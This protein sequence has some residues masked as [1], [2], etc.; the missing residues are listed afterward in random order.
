MKQ[1]SQP[2]T[3][4]NL[5]KILNQKLKYKAE[6]QRVYQIQMGAFCYSKP[7]FPQYDSRYPYTE[8]NNIIKS[9]SIEEDALHPDVSPTVFKA[10]RQNPN[11]SD[12]KESDF[13][14][15]WR[16]YCPGCRSLHSVPGRLLCCHVNI[17]ARFSK[18]E[19]PEDTDKETS[20][21]DF[22]VLTD[23]YVYFTYQEVFDHGSTLKIAAEYSFIHEELIDRETPFKCNPLS[24]IP[25]QLDL[26]LVFAKAEE[27]EQPASYIMNNDETIVVVHNFRGTAEEAMRILYELTRGS[28]HSFYSLS[29]TRNELDAMRKEISTRFS[30]VATHLTQLYELPKRNILKARFLVKMGKKELTYLRS[31]IV[32]NDTKEVDHSYSLAHVFADEEDAGYDPIFDQH[33]DSLSRELESRHQLPSSLSQSLGHFE[34]EFRTID[35]SISALFLALMAAAAGAL[36]TQ[37]LN[38]IL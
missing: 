13:K 2:E 12:I 7:K 20:N 37:I 38:L 19:K 24:P 18:L 35:Q 22:R 31:M 16:W 11:I 3:Y 9:F 8:M 30:D 4:T 25:L 32:E 10:L 27:P 21:L 28:L 15:E 26:Y 5:K 14:H 29:M 34:Q 6:I 23:G 36:V 1:D 17:P 33:A